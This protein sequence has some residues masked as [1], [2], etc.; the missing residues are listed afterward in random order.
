VK[1]SNDFKRLEIRIW[2]HEVKL[3][4]SRKGLKNQGLFNVLDSWIVG[5]FFFFFFFFFFIIFFI[6]IY[7]NFLNFKF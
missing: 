7:N 5:F 4:F 6:I 2:L 1:H 3:G